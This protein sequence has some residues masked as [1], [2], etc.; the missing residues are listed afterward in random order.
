MNQPTIVAMGSLMLRALLI[1]M[2]FIGAILVFTTVF[3]SVGQSLD[4]LIMAIARQGVIFAVV[5]WLLPQ[6]LGFAGIVWAQ[7]VSD[8]LTCAIGYGLYRHSKTLWW[9][10]AA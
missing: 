8:L 5:L 3:Q 7:A 6:W 1:T 10:P 4:A 2:P 9:Q